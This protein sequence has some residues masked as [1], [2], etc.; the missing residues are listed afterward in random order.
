M[1]GRRRRPVLG[2]A[3]LVGATASAARSSAERQQLAMEQARLAETTRRL[4]YDRQM[5]IQAMQTEE[6]VRRGI[7]S[8]EIQRRQSEQSGV[9]VTQ[10]SQPLL[11][12]NQCKQLNQVNN[13][14]CSNCGN[15]LKI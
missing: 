14:F 3:L 8:A 2:T 12:C 9:P 4:E 15:N 6:A 10:N 7:A 1:Y 11:Q 13:K 5:Q